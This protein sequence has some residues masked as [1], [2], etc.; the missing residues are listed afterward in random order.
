MK[1]N[2]RNRL[3][4]KFRTLFRLVSKGERYQRKELD[5]EANKI[6]DTFRREE[7]EEQWG[8]PAYH[9]IHH[10]RRHP[11]LNWEVNG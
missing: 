6:I 1:T 7:P 9:H 3:L 11:T 10:I 5:T 2:D 8:D 4:R